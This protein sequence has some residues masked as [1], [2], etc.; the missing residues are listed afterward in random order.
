LQTAL[1]VRLICEEV[2]VIAGGCVMVTVAL[3]TQEFASV[4]VTVYDPATS[5]VPVAPVPP[6]GDHAYVY[7]E[8]PPAGVTVAL[9]LLPPKQVT[10]TVAVM[11][12]V[13]APVEVTTTVFVITHPFA[14]VIVH[15]YDPAVSVEAVDPDPPTGAHE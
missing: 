1:H 9:P 2:F 13:M 14:S 10:F 3:A 11:L 15:V 12:A 7:G 8:V 4:T 5:A 6:L